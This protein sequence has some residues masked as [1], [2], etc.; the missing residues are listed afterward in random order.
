MNSG[1][2]AIIELLIEAIKAGDGHIFILAELKSM[3]CGPKPS[4]AFGT[5]SKMYDSFLVGVFINPKILKFTVQM[6]WVKPLK[7]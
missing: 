7:T 6:L 4:A 1:L 5:D 2:S 3:T